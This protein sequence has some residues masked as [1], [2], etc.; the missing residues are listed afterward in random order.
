MTELELGQHQ[1]CD[2][3]PPCALRSD[4][5]P[6]AAITASQRTLCAGLRGSQG[7]TRHWRTLP[8]YRRCGCMTKILPPFFQGLGE[9]VD[10]V[11]QNLM[12]T[13]WFIAGVGVSSSSARGLPFPFE[14]LRCLSIQTNILSPYFNTSCFPASSLQRHYSPSPFRALASRQ[15]S[16]EH[17]HRMSSMSLEPPRPS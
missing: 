10:A 17:H 11:D 9:E 7:Q 4:H 6:V 5:A 15:Y 8:A 16:T 14:S 2:P 1:Q 12:P 3:R 13:L